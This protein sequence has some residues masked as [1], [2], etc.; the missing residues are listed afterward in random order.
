M[1]LFKGSSISSKIH[2]VLIWIPWRR[3]RWSQWWRPTS[4]GRPK[5]SPR[6]QPTLST[7]EK[8]INI[9]NRWKNRH[10]SCNKT[11]TRVFYCSSWNP[12]S[13]RNE[14]ATFKEKLVE[15]ATEKVNL[16]SNYVYVQPKIWNFKA[17]IGIKPSGNIPER[18][19]G[20]LRK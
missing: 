5:A 17:V 10:Q 13:W 3:R 8:A 19:C 14:K 12:S 20:F 4:L 1:I 7:G 9:N 18:I 16:L 2:I 6:T 11:G 15:I